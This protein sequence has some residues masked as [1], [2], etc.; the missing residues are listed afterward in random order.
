MLT[1][2]A[3]FLYLHFALPIVRDFENAKSVFQATD[4]EPGKLQET[5]ASLD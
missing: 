4:A 3:T 2:R 5:L 1:D